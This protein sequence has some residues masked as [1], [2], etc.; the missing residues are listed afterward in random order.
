MYFRTECLLLYSVD[1]SVDTPPHRAHA[2]EDTPPHRRHT[3]RG[4]AHTQDTPREDTPTHR[5]H[6]LRGHAHTQRTHSPISALEVLPPSKCVLHFQQKL[7]CTKA[8]SPHSE[9]VWGLVY[10]LIVLNVKENWVTWPLSPDVRVKMNSG[11]FFQLHEVTSIKHLE[12]VTLEMFLL[13]PKRASYVSIKDRIVIFFPSRDPFIKLCEHAPFAF[14]R[15]IY[16][17]NT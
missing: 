5:R 10:T 4:H 16:H 11:I 8:I 14:S 1:F 13:P 3:P 2:P 15:N 17:E 9:N 6:A 7:E 12:T